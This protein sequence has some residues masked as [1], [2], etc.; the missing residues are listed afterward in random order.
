MKKNIYLWMM[1]FALLLLNGCTGSTTT[2]L[3]LD[4]MVGTPFPKK[5]KFGNTT[6]TLSSAFS[7]GETGV[8]LKVTEGNTNI[9]VLTGPIDPAEPDQY[10][11]INDAEL[12]ALETRYRALQKEAKMF[13]CGIG[14][15]NDCGL[16][17]VY[18]IIVYHWY[19]YPDKIRGKW[20]MG[21]LWDT[22]DRGSFAVFYRNQDIRLSEKKFL[23]TTA[24]E[25][26]HTFNLHH[27]DGNYGGSLMGQ[28]TS[29]VNLS[30]FFFTQQS[31]AHLK[32]HPIKCARPGT[33]SFF[34]VHSS[35]HDHPKEKDFN[36]NC[37]P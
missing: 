1:L 21:K 29:I 27:E 34:S 14:N 12:D 23:R 10:D 16:F 15:N 31:K 2:E 11:Y 9:A 18:G 32:E 24:H 5:Q 37:K 28:S 3:E 7:N 8:S 22:T 30:Q 20:V 26:G 19:E 4:R 13:K 17:Y 6:V 36:K 35:H 33:G 25:L